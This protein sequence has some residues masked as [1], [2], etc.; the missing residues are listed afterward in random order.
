MKVEKYYEI[1]IYPEEKIKAP[2]V[3]LQVNELKLDPNNVRFRHLVNELS[4]SEMDKEIWAEDDTHDLCNEIEFSEGLREPIIIDS[5]LVVREGC[6]RLVCFRHL[7]SKFSNDPRRKLYEKILAVKLP[8]GTSDKAIA[9]LLAG[10]HVSG[11]KEWKKFNQ[12][13]HIYDLVIEYKMNYED[14]RKALSM[15]KTTVVRM[16]KTYKTLKKYRELYKNDTSWFHKYSYFEEWFR[17]ED[18]KPWSESDEW[19]DKLIEW[20]GKEKIKQGVHIRKLSQILLDPE[21]ISFLDK[22]GVTFQDALDRLALVKPAIASPFYELIDKTQTAI[23]QIPRE[24]MIS[25]A[26][27]DTK[28]DMLKRL[29]NNLRL[30]ISEIEDLKPKEKREKR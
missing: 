16:V 5:N 9:I 3:K 18:L 25:T 7:L 17:R 12:A 22:D 29:Q 28:L 19:L 20:I 24:E 10:A 11:K 26:K 4:D 27:N 2:I 6:R 23:F 30:L 13:A 15:S 1:S 21:L 14:I 8:Q